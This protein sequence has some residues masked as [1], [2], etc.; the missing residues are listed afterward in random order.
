MALQHNYQRLL[1]SS[2][3][4]L[5]EGS[6]LA[7]SPCVSSM[8]RQ[9]CSSHKVHK[10]IQEASLLPEPWGM[11]QMSFRHGQAI[12]LALIRT[13]TCLLSLVFLSVPCVHYPIGSRPLSLQVQVKSHCLSEIFIATG[14]TKTTASY[15]CVVVQSR[16]M[17]CP[18]TILG[19]G[20]RKSSK[21]PHLS[22]TDQEVVQAYE[23][24]LWPLSQKGFSS[25]NSRWISV[26][27][28]RLATTQGSGNV[29]EEGVQRL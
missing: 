17:R 1:G 15:K 13:Q 12:S 24:P 14:S 9:T 28:P 27:P 6:T 21:P 26:S 8:D 3:T 4:A 7:L 19:S 29:S 23:A 22:F 10:M 16:W 25:I 5:Y 2:Q 18:F 11:S 20:A